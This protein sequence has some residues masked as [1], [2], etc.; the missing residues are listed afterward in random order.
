MC[1]QWTGKNTTYTELKILDIKHPHD[2]TECGTV[3]YVC[4]EVFNSPLR[5]EQWCNSTRQDQTVKLSWKSL[6]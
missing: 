3:R 5:V 6:D 2:I 4:D 1:T